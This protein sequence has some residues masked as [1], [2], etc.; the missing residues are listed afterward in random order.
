MF[1]FTICTHL[2]KLRQ[3]AELDVRPH[4]CFV[5]IICEVCQD[6][7]SPA[8]Q[9][10]IEGVYSKVMCFDRSLPQ[11]FIFINCNLSDARVG[12]A[13]CEM[14]VKLFPELLRHME[15]VKPRV[16]V[17]VVGQAEARYSILCYDVRSTTLA[18]EDES[19]DRFLS[20]RP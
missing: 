8:F 1:Q 4:L 20:S 13:L 10:K 5:K 18:Q 11:E 19:S 15:F 17:V 3:K 7:I 16:K 6:F 12:L 2:G 9:L 14:N